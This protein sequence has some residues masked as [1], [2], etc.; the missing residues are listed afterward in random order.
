LTAM[1]TN[2]HRVK[3]LQQGAHDYL[4]K[5]NAI[6]ELMA[7]VRT[8]H[9]RGAPVIVESQIQAADLKDDYVRRKVTRGATRNT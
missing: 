1:G 7:R 4:V 8:L 3:G 9:R 5:P 2:E 6:A